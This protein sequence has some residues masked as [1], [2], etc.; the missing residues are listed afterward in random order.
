MV[1]DQQDSPLN[2]GLQGLTSAVHGPTLVNMKELLGTD[3]VHLSLAM[4]MI[5]IGYLLAAVLCGLIFNR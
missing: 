1:H 5:S 4:S 3:T 2:V